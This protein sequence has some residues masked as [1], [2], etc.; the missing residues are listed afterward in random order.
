MDWQPIKTAPRDGTR[1]L[2]FGYSNTGVRARIHEG[3]WV[4]RNGYWDTGRGRVHPTHWMPR[5]DHPHHFKFI[6]A[7]ERGLLDDDLVTE[8]SSS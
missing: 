3:H 6:G 8:T 2:L 5:P 1:V 7:R 4:R